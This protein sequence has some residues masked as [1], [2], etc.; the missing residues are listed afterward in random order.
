MSRQIEG[1]TFNNRIGPFKFLYF[2]TIGE[3]KV[4][5][6]AKLNKYGVPLRIFN[7]DTELDDD[8]ASL[9]FY[10]IQPGTEFR[11]DFGESQ[12]GGKKYKTLKQRKNNKTKKNIKK[13]KN[14]K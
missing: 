12:N 9:D 1:I 6:R 7:G 3:L 8:M 13:R 2:A 4:F 14:K 11:Y 10:G 5:L